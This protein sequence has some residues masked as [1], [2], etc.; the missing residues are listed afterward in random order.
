MTAARTVGATFTIQ[1]HTLTV[2]APTNGTIT[3]TGITCGTGGST[4]SATYD[5]GT[6]VPLT[7]T[8]DANYNFGGWTGACSGTGACSVTMTAAQAVGGSFTIQRYI[9]TVT[10][11]SHGTITAT[12]ITCGTGGVDCTET[13]DWGSV[14]PLGVTPDTGYRLRTWAGACTGFGACSLT[15]TAA[16]TVGGLFTPTFQQRKGDPSPYTGPELILN[17]PAARSGATPEVVTDPVRPLEPEPAS[18]PEAKVEPTPVT[19]SAPEPKTETKPGL[20]PKDSAWVPDVPRVV[21]SGEV[22]NPGAYAWF[23]GMTVR[24]LI[25]VAG[26][27]TPGGPEDRLEI[28]CEGGGQGR[29]DRFEFDAL[30]KAGE[31]F[32][33][34]RRPF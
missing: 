1:R 31:A 33:V 14:V 19:R 17:A 9:L 5:Y 24:Q 18:A 28:V 8:P 11:P 4:C 2:T 6:V 12:G 32:V 27:V 25:A 3:G 10:A 7:A 21:V 16:R 13:Y 34:R 23:P 30:V 20:A 26:G 29:E 22:R 15:M